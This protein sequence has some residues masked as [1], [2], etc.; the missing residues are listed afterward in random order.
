MSVDTGYQSAMIPV[1]QGY[2]VKPIHETKYLAAEEHKVDCR[3][4]RLEN[5][6]NTMV[7]ENH[8]A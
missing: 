2:D 3:Q 7:N 8:E 1:N 6:H 5:L 4:D